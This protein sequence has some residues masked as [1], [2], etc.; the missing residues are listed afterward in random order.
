LLLLSG[1]VLCSSPLLNKQH[2]SC[3]SSSLSFSLSLQSL[4]DVTSTSETEVAWFSS[5][6]ELHDLMP[7]W[8]LL[9]KYPGFSALKAAVESSEER[10]FFSLCQTTLSHL[11]NVHGYVSFQYFETEKYCIDLNVSTCEQSSLI[12]KKERKAFFSSIF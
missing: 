9:S 8:I 10:S 4:V 7:V 6:E 1:T 3:T 5:K 12:F 11:T 2:F